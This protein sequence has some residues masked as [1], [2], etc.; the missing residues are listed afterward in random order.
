[1]A[2]HGAG[3]IHVEYSRLESPGTILI[4]TGEDGRTSVHRNR[5]VSERGLTGIHAGTTLSILSGKA[6]ETT[7]N[8]NRI[9]AEEEAAISS[10]G[11]TRVRENNFLGS[12]DITIDGPSCEARH[13]LPEVR[14]AD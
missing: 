4:Q 12:G 7:V 3:L 13:N 2:P 1:M 11:R 5:G 14:C 6:G 9:I 10:G 8:E